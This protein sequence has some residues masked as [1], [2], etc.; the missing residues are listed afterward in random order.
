MAGSQCEWP[1]AAVNSQPT[2]GDH[3][4][5]PVG[6]ARLSEPGPTQ[7]DRNND[8][9]RSAGGGGRKGGGKKERKNRDLKCKLSC[10]E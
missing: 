7:L 5:Q 2:T 10:G 1:W 6:S 9:N 4:P 3:L 8:L